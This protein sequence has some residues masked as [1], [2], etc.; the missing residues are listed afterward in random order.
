MPGRRRLRL[1]LVDMSV[2]L[3]RLANREKRVETCDI[4]SVERSFELIRLEGGPVD[5]LCSERE[6]RERRER[7][8]ERL[9]KWSRVTSCQKYDAERHGGGSYEGDRLRVGV[10][11]E[12][13]S[14]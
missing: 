3:C 11:I 13:C 8:A 10:S 1:Y 6:R 9:F 5:E 7:E 2:I 12:R 14:T 4:L